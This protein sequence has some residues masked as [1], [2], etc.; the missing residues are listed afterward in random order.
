MGETKEKLRAIAR[1]S[2]DALSVAD[3]AEKSRLIQERVLQFSPYI[4]SRA[5]ALYSST[6]NEVAT[7]EIRDHAFKE[8]KKVFYP[9]VA[10]DTGGDFVEL[11]RGGELRPGRYGILEPAG[12]VLLTQRDEEELVVFV[13]ALAF[14]LLGNRLGGGKGWYDR[15]LSRLGACVTLAGLAYEFQMFDRLPAER[16]DC[17]VDHIITE[18]R[19]VDS[20]DRPSSDSGWVP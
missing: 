6:Q 19:V 20:G 1:R 8:G 7:V 13:P 12:D 10:G 15:A 18:R 3:A 11:K 17:K 14:D 2:R 16:W 4:F 9:R 5:V